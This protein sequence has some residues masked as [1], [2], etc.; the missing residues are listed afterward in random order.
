MHT[1]QS[2]AE[3]A[4]A[5]AVCLLPNLSRWPSARGPAMP[6]NVCHRDAA[7][8]SLV[9]HASSSCVGVRVIGGV[10]SAPQYVT[11][12]KERAGGTATCQRKQGAGARVGAQ[13]AGPH[14][15]WQSL[16]RKDLRVV[17]SGEPRGAVDFGTRKVAWHSLM[18]SSGSYST[19]AHENQHA[20]V[21]SSEGH[22]T[23]VYKV[24]TRLAIWAVIGASKER[25]ESRSGVS[26]RSR[27]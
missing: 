15:N 7:S 18:V 19:R 11:D 1:C 27:A 9:T 21:L 2:S 20:L 8:Q 4:S 6:R 5:V 24:P 12:R 3:S 10:L 13:A 22:C 26:E 16:G 25:E 17:G 14:A 23:G